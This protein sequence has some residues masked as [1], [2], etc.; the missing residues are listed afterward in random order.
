MLIKN[1]CRC[2]NNKF[3]LITEKL[4]EGYLNKKAIL[5]CEPDSQDVKEIKCTDCG[6]HYKMQDFEQIDY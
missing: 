5:V 1:G 6:R 3:F 2:G 4:Y